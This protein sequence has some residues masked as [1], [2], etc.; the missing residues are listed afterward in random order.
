MPIGVCLTAVIL[1]SAILHQIKRLNSWLHQVYH[2]ATATFFLIHLEV[3]FQIL[4]SFDC[5]EFLGERVLADDL[6]QQC[7]STSESDDGAHLKFI[8]GLCIPFGLLWIFVVPVSQFFFGKLYIGHIHQLY[9]SK[10]K[11]S[12]MSSEDKTGLQK[13]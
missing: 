10:W 12:N 7:F 5:I 8:L 3:A 13:T 1:L 9:K 11:I 2:V 4:T 6:G